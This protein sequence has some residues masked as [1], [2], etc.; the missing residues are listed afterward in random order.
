[1]LDVRI[2]VLYLDEM[3]DKGEVDG[4]YAYVNIIV[5]CVEEMM[6]WGDAMWIL[7]D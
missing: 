5:L 7:F 1:M 3:I 2:I 6:I 4:G